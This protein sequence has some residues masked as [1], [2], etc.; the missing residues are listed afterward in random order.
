MYKE[1]PKKSK[2]FRFCN[3]PLFGRF[4]PSA[5][6]PNDSSDDFSTERPVLTSPRPPLTHFQPKT[7]FFHDFGRFQ[8]FAFCG[9]KIRSCNFSL[10]GRFWPSSYIPN[11]SSDDFSTERPVFTSPRP[12]LTHFRPK[13]CFFPGF[14]PF[15]N[16]RPRPSKN[17]AQLLYNYMRELEA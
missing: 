15:S 6:I 4:W 8:T 11:D 7:C 9:Q 16:F 3:F 1:K 13:T 5:Y 17:E 14:R 12:T 2:I 10:F